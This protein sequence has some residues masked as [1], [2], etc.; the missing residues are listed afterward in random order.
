M[1]ARCRTLTDHDH[2]EEG[3][4]HTLEDGLEVTVNGN[5]LG[6][7]RMALECEPCGEVFEN[8]SLAIVHADGWHPMVRADEAVVALQ[9]AARGED[10]KR[11]VCVVCFKRFRS[12]ADLKV[13]FRKHT[14][15]VPYGCEVCGKGFTAKGNL[16]VHLRVHTGER[17]FAC[18]V[19][20]M[21]FTVKINLTKHLRVHTGERPFACEI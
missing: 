8:A 1:S 9:A 5:P 15:E 3:P 6:G 16:T 12:P 18:S 4:F 20:D 14:G 11:D 21:R 19:C 17:P 7:F 2:R 13:H 10:K